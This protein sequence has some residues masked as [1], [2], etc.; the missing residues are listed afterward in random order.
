MRNQKWI[1][2]GGIYYPVN[3]G[4]EITDNIGPGIWQVY[5]SPNPMDKRLGLTLVADKFTFDYKIY[6][7]G[8]SDMFDKIKTVWNSKLYVESNRN[9]GIIY[10]GIKGTGK[11]VSAKLLCNDMKI[12]TIIV[13]HSYEG[14]ILD[15]IQSLEFECIIFIDEAEK[16][17]TG[18]D[19]QI[20]LKMIDGVYNK[21]RKL[22]L[23][24]TNTLSVNENLISRPGRIRYIQEF[25]NLSASA[26]D[27]YINDNLIDKSKKDQVIETVDL[28]E[29]S[30]IDILKAI[31]EEV[32]ILGFIDSKTNLN[33]PR[34][35]FVFDVLYIRGATEENIPKV[36]ELIGEC[37][38]DT[39]LRLWLDEYSDNEKYP[40]S[41]GEEN[42]Y[43]IGETIGASSS[44]TTK[45]TTRFDVFFQGQS[46][47]L[48]EILKKPG[49]FS[50]PRFFTT[51]NEW[52]GETC[53]CVILRQRG[54]PSLY[55]GKLGTAAPL[56]L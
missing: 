43:R 37:P 2:E 15:F 10:N 31:V 54:N 38:K 56:V 22:Y 3:A 32:N 50:D 46:T 1:N 39:E 9:L 14:L 13:N 40:D 45:L 25:G 18:D 51:K 4:V 20:L 36:L 35:N 53:L 7:L 12:P 16:T 47:N 19:Q 41:D 29:I 11:T 17:F 23:L 52:D 8:G 5:Q 49:D 30:T 6:D 42:S 21:S 33:I 48:G 44:Y 26:V 28:L 34:A 24:T 27:M 55:G